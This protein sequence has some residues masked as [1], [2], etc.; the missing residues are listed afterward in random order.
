MNPRLSPES[1]ARLDALIEK[2][3]LQECRDLIQEAA[4]ECAI[5]ELKE[6]DDYSQMGNS[7]YGGSPDFPRDW[8]WPQSDSGEPLLFLMQINLSEVPPFAGKE[9]RESGILY[10]FMDRDEEGYS[11][12]TP[13]FPLFPAY[14]R[15][16]FYDG[17]FSELTCTAAPISF[18]HSLIAHHIYIT[19][20]I[21]FPEDATSFYNY[22][23]P[24]YYEG[25]AFHKKLSSSGLGI[26]EQSH[27]ALQSDLWDISVIEGRYNKR[28]AG[29]LMGF[30][31]END[32]DPRE[33]AFLV[34][35]DNAQ[36][37]VQAEWR[38]ENAD[39]VQAGAA[40]WQLFWKLYESHEVGVNF[41][42]PGYLEIFI[43]QNDLE[44]FNFDN[45]YI[46]QVSC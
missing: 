10:L 3:H 22:G 13:L 24:L 39:A 16:F 11:T 27:H 18:S 14:K 19:T 21:D 35:N 8:Q 31:H 37:I 26:D 5:I 32:G 33:E 23:Q 25:S 43:H 36:R 12:N 40:Q 44:I 42:E 17:D 45:V 30:P 4:M 9:L 7:R 46:I 6:A 34:H 2:H 29:K 20:S 1:L 38:R 41:G 15:V 28:L